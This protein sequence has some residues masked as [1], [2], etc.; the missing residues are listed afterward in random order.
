MK[1]YKILLTG[2]MGAGKTTAISM[3]SDVPPVTTEVQ[4]NDLSHSKE[5]TT[6]GL[7]YGELTLASGERLRLYGTPGQERFRF[8]W[9]ILAQGALGVVILLDHS[10]PEPFQD[11]SLYLNNFAELIANGA[12]VVAVGRLR[13]E[14]FDVLDEYARLTQEHGVI[15]PVVAV[16]VRDKDQVLNLLDLLF[17]QLETKVTQA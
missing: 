12:C 13:R 8:M 2:S 17:L 1:E 14:E 7:D 11:L 6:V 15:C 16:D 3:I 10:R 5:T 9:K 4:N